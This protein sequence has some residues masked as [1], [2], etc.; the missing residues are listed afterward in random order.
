MVVQNTAQSKNDK[1]L[2][3]RPPVV[4]VL[5]H[6]DHGKSSL[7]E[8]IREDFKITA[9]E[10]GGITQHMG[11]YV[12]EYQGKLI[13]FLD[14]PGHEAF[15]AT[16][17]R[18]AHVAD[19]A[20]LVV[21]ADEGV[22][23]QTKEAIEQARK[24]GLPLLVALN[25][26]DKPEANP[27]RVK[28]E[29]SQ[30]EIFVES[31]GGKV[32][33]IETSAT[34]KKGISELLEMI[35][36]M[37]DLEHKNIDPS[38][39]G[40]GVVIESS[41]DPKR[42]PLATLLVQNGVVRPGD[43]IGTKS[44][45]GKVRTLQDFQGESVQSGLPSMPILAVGF[46][47]CPQVGEVF[48]VF[49]SEEAARAQL[50]ASPLGRPA[51]VLVIPQ[52]AKTL[53]LVLKVD[54]A[55]SLEVLVSALL[56]LP[57]EH[58]FVRLVD[59]GVGVIGDKDVRLAQGTHARIV[60]FRTQVDPT[61]G[62]LAQREGIVL[63]TFDVI[64]DLIQRVRT[65]LEQEIVQELVTVDIGALSVLAVFLTEKNRQIVGGK[66]MEGEVR[67]KSQMKIFR[68]EVELGTGK[69]INLQKDKKDTEVVRKGEECGILYE[70]PVKIQQGDVLTF[71]IQEL[72]NKVL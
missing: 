35:L 72:Q 36:L 67:K 52:G 50:I 25:K 28:Q 29:L 44:A 7:L 13:T 12:V 37:A 1:T 45:V 23:L 22:K 43:V 68:N 6:V 16:R 51:Q 49:E 47:A 27:E 71:S 15:S 56:S 32:P 55:G 54:M 38:K 65:W 3:A 11:A 42:G 66:V 18:G 57:Q 39:P 34:S 20:V 31:F 59:A 26:I 33:C 30:E 60:G 40:E 4:V 69:I 62:D 61:A 53:D 8:A 64:Y 9:K 58:V 41:M 5:G 70:G 19:I 63:E 46:E 21:A 2:T 24:A 17:A 14:T 10:S 48:Q